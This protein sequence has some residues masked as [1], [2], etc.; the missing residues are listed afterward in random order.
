VPKTK[1][2]LTLTTLLAFCV[3]VFGAYVGLTDAGLG[4]ADWP[5]CYGAISVPDIAEELSAIEESFPD[6]TTWPGMDSSMADSSSAVS[7][8]LIKP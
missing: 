3:I 5:G 2:T 6:S 1:T 4:C 8:T 7:G